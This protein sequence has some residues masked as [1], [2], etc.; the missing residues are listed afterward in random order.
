VVLATFASLLLAA[1][2]GGAWTQLAATL[3]GV[4]ILLSLAS[5]KE[6]GASTRRSTGLLPGS[7]K[8]YMRAD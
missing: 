1:V 7:S 8:T 6:L 5:F 4:A 3:G 2:H